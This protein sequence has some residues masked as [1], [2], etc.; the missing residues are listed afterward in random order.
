MEH[1][2]STGKFVDRNP[3]K[4]FAFSYLKGGKSVQAKEQGN[5][6]L[7][8]S[9]GSWEGRG[10]ERKGMV[11]PTSRLRSPRLPGNSHTHTHTRACTHTQGFVPFAEQGE[12][13][14]RRRKLKC[15]LFMFRDV[16]PLIFHAG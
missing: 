13:E 11:S 10:K 16:T 7:L 1:G 8:W 14:E 15:H 12:G 6:D 3:D 9:Q 4:E 5:Q 2:D